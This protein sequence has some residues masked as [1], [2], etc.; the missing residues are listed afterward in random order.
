MKQMQVL[1][2]TGKKGIVAMLLL[3]PM[4]YGVKEHEL[5]R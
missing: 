4:N 2:Q 3:V 5:Q 1:G